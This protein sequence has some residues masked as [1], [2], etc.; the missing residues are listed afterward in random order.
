LLRCPSESVIPIV[1]LVEKWVELSFR[2]SPTPNILD[3]ISVTRLG[4]VTSPFYES[5]RMF[6][7]WGSGD[8][9]RVVGVGYWPIDVS[10]QTD[11]VPHSYFNIAFNEGVDRSPPE[12]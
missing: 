3:Y 2:V 8:D 11:T 10:I 12:F 4:E 5:V 6:E 1:N 9:Y 7:I